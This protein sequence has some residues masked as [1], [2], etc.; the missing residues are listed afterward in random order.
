M[1]NTRGGAIIYMKK[2]FFLV[3]AVLTLFLSMTSAA[4]A[5]EQRDNAEVYLGSYSLGSFSS[6]VSD[7]CTATLSHMDLNINN[8]GDAT[9]KLYVESRGPNQTWS[10]F[11]GPFTTSG[12]VTEYY[13]INTIEGYDYRF[14]IINNSWITDA[15]GFVTCD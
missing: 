12:N 10:T 7:Y 14:R 11:D 2:K 3:I 8:T 1:E 6:T 4:S 5:V 15:S 9:V 13:N